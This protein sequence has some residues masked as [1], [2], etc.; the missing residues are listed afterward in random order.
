MDWYRR[1]GDFQKTT[2]DQKY[3]SITTFNG[4]QIS[5]IPFL[6]NEFLTTLIAY[7]KIKLVK[8]AIAPGFEIETFDQNL[9]MIIPNHL[10]D[11]LYFR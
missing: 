7:N 4:F 2:N 6:S 11:K 10:H 5:T 8:L 9:L 3:F 1:T